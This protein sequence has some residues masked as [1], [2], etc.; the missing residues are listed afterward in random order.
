MR[1]Q[2]GLAQLALAHVEVSLDLAAC[3]QR[4]RRDE[5]LSQLYLRLSQWDR[6][7]AQQS[8]NFYDVSTSFMLLARGASFARLPTPAEEAVMEP[9]IRARLLATLAHLGGYP[10]RCGVC[11]AAL[12]PS[13]E[14]IA[15]LRP[16]EARELAQDGAEHMRQRLPPGKYCHAWA[17]DR[18]P[19]DDLQVSPLE[20]QEHFAREV[21]YGKRV[22]LLGATP[23]QQL[24]QALRFAAQV[25]AA[26]V[27]TSTLFQR[28]DDFLEDLAGLLANVDLFL[29]VGLPPGLGA[30]ISLQ[31]TC[32]FGVQALDAGPLALTATP[33]PR[34]G[35]P[36]QTP[37]AEE[38]EE[39]RGLRPASQ[40]HSLNGPW[41]VQVTLDS[42]T[43]GQLQEEAWQAMEVPF[44]PQSHRGLATKISAV[45]AVWYR[46]ELL[47][48]AAWC[49]GGLLQLHVDACDWECAFYLGSVSLGVHR[50]GYD[51]FRLDLPAAVCGQR[52]WLM[53]RAW[54]PTDEGCAFT[55]HPPVPC[56]ACCETG[57]QPRGKQALKP[58]SIMYTAVTGLWRQGLWIEKLPLCHIAELSF[59]VPAP[60]LVEVSISSSCGEQM[61]VEVLS[62]GRSLG[63][64]SGPCCS[65]QLV[66]DEELKP[67]SPEVPQLYDLIVAMGSDL[68][69]TSLGR[70]HVAASGGLMQLN[71][72]AVFMHGV[73]YQGY[74]PES[75]LTP[76]D[77]NAIR[78]DLQAIKAAGFNTVRVH[79][80]VMGADFYALCDEL[81]LLVW[82]DMPAGDMRAMP[83]WSDSRAIAEETGAGAGVR[84]EEI[85]RSE[86]SRSTFRLELEAMLRW[87]RPFP[88]IV[89]W[90]LFNEGWG[91]AETA[92]TVE[93]VREAD[94]TRL[95]DAAS[96]WNEL[97]PLG[98]FA[99]IHNYEDNS[100]IFGPLPE[101][102][103]NFAAW[104][105]NV[106]GRIPVLGEYG[107]LGC[108]I[109]GHLWSHTAWGYG[110]KE[111]NRDVEVL[112][113]GL[114][115]L[116]G[117]LAQAICMGVGAA[118][119][120]QW[121][122]VETE[123][124]G[125]LTYD[126]HMKLPLEF[127]QEFSARVMAAFQHCGPTEGQSLS[128]GLSLQ[129]GRMKVKPLK[130]DGPERDTKEK[131]WQALEGATK[132]RQPMCAS[133]QGKKKPPPVEEGFFARLFSQ[134][135]PA[136]E[137]KE[138]SDYEEDQVDEVTG[139]VGAHCYTVLSAVEAAANG[140]KSWFRTE[141][142]LRLRNPWGTGRW[143]GPGR[144]P[145]ILPFVDCD[146]G[147]DA[148]RRPEAKPDE[149]EGPE[150]PLQEV[151]AGTFWIRFADFCEEFS[152]VGV[153][154]YRPGHVSS[155]CRLA[156]Q[157]G[158]AS[159]ANCTLELVAEGQKP[160]EV[161]VSV[162]QESDE[163][164]NR[165]KRRKYSAARIELLEFTSP[166]SPGGAATQC[167]Q[168]ARHV[169]SSSFAMQREVVLEANLKPG[170]TYLAVV[171]WLQATPPQSWNS[172]CT[173]RVYAPCR[174]KLCP[175]VS[176]N[177]ARREA[178]EAAAM[179]PRGKCLKEEQGAQLR[180]WSDRE[181]GTVVLLLDAT[182]AP[183]GLLASVSWT[184]QN[185]LLQPHFPDWAGSVQAAGVAEK[186]VQ[187]VELQPGQRQLT[188]VSWLDPNKA[189]SAS[190]SWQAA[191][192]PCAECSAPVGTAVP[193]RFSGA[194]HKLD[195]GAVH[196]ECYAS[197]MQRTAQRCIHCAKPVAQINGFGGKFF[198]F[199]AQKLGDHPGGAV[200]AECCEAFQRKFAQ[201]CLQCGQ[202]VMRIEGK[203][204]GQHFNYKDGHYGRH[205]EGPVHE[206]CHGAFLRKWAPSCAHC[207]EP[208]VKMGG[209]SGQIFEIGPSAKKVH[210]ECLAE[211]QGK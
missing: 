136:V 148:R 109:D 199:E 147:K 89:A 69:R 177:Q 157:A 166:G 72:Q 126:R 74:W 120:T 192:E 4:W 146:L 13:K 198:Q 182:S 76:P 142:W 18:R 38:F 205:G 78:R 3:D 121:N 209:F 40:R 195:T 186:H 123:V 175:N 161:V 108:A 62:S 71:G 5:A 140:G 9:K 162:I 180:C 60:S 152:T 73:L 133:C 14:A 129:G 160:C 19:W 116:L 159:Q 154:K 82:Q 196:E 49:T 127:F 191:A 21:V 138:E 25:S 181:A 28:S 106:S 112:A 158:K 88:S 58:G 85:R 61:V 131:V 45:E 114:E 122:D 53:V 87:L 163:P 128:K 84:L 64:A 156:P 10:E 57:W 26:G 98:H 185:A 31:V 16:G 197:Y 83:L 117:R 141:R 39:P 23:N 169:A 143:K 172:D 168:G 95:I 107:G 176:S 90:V 206:E 70:R 111:V 189:F 201:R 54:D 41:Q 51:P 96:G 190:Y 42:A 144:K 2:L 102:F 79:A 203:Y 151:D 150:G 184:L 44:A 165:N 99:D 170:V 59:D 81:G 52:T 7:G 171:H 34:P 187:V 63:R 200:H 153:S 207:K 193:G 8:H 118:I 188:V 110:D 12:D 101:S 80:V 35:P 167:T 66:L 55:D 134:A 11:V 1:F 15:S 97:E 100:S 43:P 115:K 178:Y 6:E 29:L 194:Y 103:L 174:A 67:W 91:Q 149:Q 130:A 210:E 137:V 135:P 202:H 125:L 208:L 139:L 33:G 75:L 68:L 56:E 30:L 132:K 94:P 46:R 50:G 119:Y 48:D 22:L 164:F 183:A 104:G 65:L 155:L 145:G 105:Y 37:K 36:L 24:A 93:W 113:V 20:I 173:L 124:N 27:D 77:S 211:F 17:L 47:L 32:R 86:A 204:S 179:G 92:A